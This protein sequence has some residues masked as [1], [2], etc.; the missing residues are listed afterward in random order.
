MTTYN[1][2]TQNHPTVSV[3][4]VEIDKGISLIVQW[5]WDR[6]IVTTCS[7]QGGDEFDCGHCDQT[8]YTDAYIKFATF[9]DAV[10]F[11]EYINERDDHALVMIEAQVPCDCESDPYDHDGPM[12]YAVFWM[13]DAT[14]AL[15]IPLYKVY[16]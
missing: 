1:P 14:P 6:G 2:D 9:K 4:G 12:E 7:C 16:C 10:E 11:A 15:K 3:N 5:L 8:H 13:W